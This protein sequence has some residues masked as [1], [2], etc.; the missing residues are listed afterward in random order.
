MNDKIIRRLLIIASAGLAVSGII[1]SCIYI[2]EETKNNT[3]LC[4]A[5]GSIVL[6]N[7]FN[8]VRGLTEKRV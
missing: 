1:F 4:L 3:Y 7:L 6:S 8:V 5:L 2:F